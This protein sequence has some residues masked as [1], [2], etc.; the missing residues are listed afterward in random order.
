MA[1]ANMIYSGHQLWYRQIWFNVRLRFRFDFHD[2]IILNMWYL[3]PLILN[4]MKVFY[5]II[6]YIL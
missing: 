2:V 1:V 4:P 5:V 6:L 3:E